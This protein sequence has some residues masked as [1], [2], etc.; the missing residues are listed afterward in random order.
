[1]ANPLA[2]GK[3]GV[4]AMGAAVEHPISSTHGVFTGAMTRQQVF[5]VLA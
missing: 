3:I 5:G 2:G 4:Q 1:L